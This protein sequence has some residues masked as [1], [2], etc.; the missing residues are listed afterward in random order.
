MPAPIAGPAPAAFVTLDPARRPVQPGWSAARAAM[1]LLGAVAVPAGADPAVLVELV[2]GRI[3]A[4]DPEIAAEL[5]LPL[6]AADR[7]KGVAPSAATPRAP[8][9]RL[10][11]SSAPAPLLA[12]L[13][14]HGGDPCAP[15]GRRRGRRWR[16]VGASAEA[17]DPLT[18]TRRATRPGVAA[19][20]S[21]LPTRRPRTSE[22]SSE[23]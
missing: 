11:A 17:V 9:P 14:A 16:T 8:L 22:T 2:V 10:E 4:G 1:R 21:G 5:E 12:V 13:A 23:S 6:P 19:V 18:A 15:G 3:R 20:S 7:T